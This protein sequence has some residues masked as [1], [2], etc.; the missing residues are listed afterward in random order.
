MAFVIVF[1]AYRVCRRKGNTGH[2]FFGKGVHNFPMVCTLINHRNDVK[3][4]YTQVLSADYIAVWMI[5]KI[6][7]RLMQITLQRTRPATYTSKTKLR[8][9]LDW[10]RIENEIPMVCGIFVEGRRQTLLYFCK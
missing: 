10:L 8:M 9:T 7:G 1:V 3:L 4:F 2:P 5:T 6:W